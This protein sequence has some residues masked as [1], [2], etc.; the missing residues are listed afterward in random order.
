MNKSL[1]SII[2][3]TKDRPELLKQALESIAKQIY[4]PVY[5]VIVNDG[6]ASID[7]NEIKTILDEIE[8]KYI[9]HVSNLGRSA[10]LNTG[11]ANIDG[12]FV[13]F[14][15][16]DDL[17]YPKG[18]DR[19][20]KA[21]LENGRMP[22]YGEV[23]CSEYLNS[24]NTTET[25]QNERL[26]EPFDFGKLIFE[27][28]IP[29]N[30]LLV[31]V[32]FI[33]KVGLFD[34]N[35]EIYEDWDWILRLIEKV[36]PVFVNNVV[37]EYRTFS[38]S[39][40]TGKGGTAYHK[41]YKEKLLE[42]HK[43][44][45]IPK[46]YLDHVQ[47]VVDRIVLEKEK[48]FNESEEQ[49]ILSRKECKHFY[50]ETVKL[51]S[52]IDRYKE[53]IYRYKEEIYRYK[54]EVPRYKEELVRHQEELQNYKEHV[55][56]LNENIRRQENEL[57][58]YVDEKKMPAV[59]VVIV[60]YNGMEY[61]PVCL[62]SL[63][64]S[65]YPDFSV[66]IVDNG[67]MD[68]SVNWIKKHYPQVTLIQSAQNLGFGRANSIGV[69]HGTAPYTALLNNDTKVDKDWL[70]QLVES[71]LDNETCGAVC[72]KLLFMDAP[73]LVNAAGGGMNFIGYGYDHDFFS[74][75]KKE[76]K[77]IKD[78]FFP[79]AAAC[80]IKRSVFKDIGGFDKTFFMYH[81][82]VDLGWRMWLKGYSVKYISDSIVYHAFGGTSLKSG[83]M[84]FRN[85][86]GLRHALRSL[87]KNYEISTLKKVLPIFFRLGIRNAFNGVPTG[88]FKALLWNFFKMPSTIY[89]RFKI[90]GSRKVSDQELSVLI[91]QDIPLPV[92]FP[93][94]TA[95]NCESF[96]KQDNHDSSSSSSSSMDLISNV[97]NN[98]GYGWYPV[99]VYFGDGSTLYRWTREEAVFYFQHSGATALIGF[100]V[101]VLSKM[102]G[103]TRE[104]SVILNN[105]K[106]KK[107]AFSSDGWEPVQIKYSGD[108]GPVEVK[109]CVNDTWCPH[110]IINNHD[111]RKL[112]IG[113]KG[114]SISYEL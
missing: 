47:R 63:Y 41:R 72:S 46:Y 9:E 58:K 11:I 104:F 110:E 55:E 7:N 68:N 86:L 80:L 29:I 99:E 112:G 19:L 25:L 23:V 35:F 48:V 45:I 4:R 96:A 38:S 66:I 17:V 89:E 102:V 73:N 87:L 53:E 76:D 88:F 98:L 81:E 40:L 36:S 67:S 62:E 1:V 109:I 16:D 83:S 2:V 108:P 21:S 64:C 32:M 97:D 79:T 82:D 75:D 13:Y 92:H 103:R 42:K 12:E 50:E 70:R 51:K 43:N 10:A 8:F 22:V 54:E 100:D 28:Y 34:E 14:L 113:I 85:R 26:G 60:N 91:W 94:Y 52:E 93:D 101:L 65:D 31:P 24:K 20:V 111:Y 33:E 56:W 74:V 57:Q 69:E 90:Q 59:D 5:P 49:N 18:I 27:N 77:G 15:D 61:L 6:G 3:R 107:F 78:V 44:K 106:Q 71:M 84:E 37:A 39:T 95:A 30:S 105:V 114:T